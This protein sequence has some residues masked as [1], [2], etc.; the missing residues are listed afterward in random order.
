MSFGGS[1]AASET[2]LDTLFE[3]PSGHSN[4]AFIAS[5]GDNGQPEYPAVSPNVLAVGGTSL[6]AGTSGNYVSEVGWSNSGGGVSEFENQPIFQQGI[7]GENLAV[8]S[9]TPMRSDPDVAFDANPGAGIGGVP[10]YSPINQVGDSATPWVRQGG[11][12]F[13]APA[14]AGLIAIAD[15]GRVSNGLQTLGTPAGGAQTGP[16][17][18]LS[19]IYSLPSSDFNSVAIGNNGYSAGPGYDFITGRRYTNRQ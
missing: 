13:A 4:V 19:A 10:I 17:V 18:L 15:Q 6:T 3:T 8:D 16:N 14:W 9:A 7:V 12:S 11:T 5:A 2:S 1:E